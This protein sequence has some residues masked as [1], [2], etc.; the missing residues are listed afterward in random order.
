MAYIDEMQ[1][2]EAITL[3]L[4]ATLREIHLAE[5]TGQLRAITLADYKT[6]RT[7]NVQTCILACGGLE[8][9]R[10]MLLLA[11][12][13]PSVSQ[14]W[15]STL[16]RFYMGH[17]S[18]KIA[19]LVLRDPRTIAELDF[20]V[21]GDHFARRRFTLQ[22]DTLR[23]EQLLN[24]AFWADNPPF[25]DAKHRNGL[26]SAVWLLL[27]IPFIGRRLLSEGVRVSHV[28]PSPFQ[29]AGHLSNLVKSP[30]SV[31]WSAMQLLRDRYLCSPRKPGFI[32]RNN[33]GRYALHYHAEQLPT[34]S[35]FVSL[36]TDKDSLGVQRLVVDFNYC[37]LDATSVVR[38]HDILDRSLREANVG[39]L[40]YRTSR[41][42]LV[43][44]V[45]AQ[46]S[47]GFHQLGTTRMSKDANS[48]VVDE[49]CKVHGL[50]NLFLLSSSV[51]PSSGQANPTF[52]IVAFAFRLASYLTAQ[53]DRTQSSVQHFDRQ[54]GSV[55]CE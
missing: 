23:N 54:I 6:S 7:I 5:G 10:I 51:F 55:R 19:D 4:G 17:I 18:G 29:I 44:S 47:D 46:A 2:S 35:S 45:M 40:E 16:G 3:L 31:I 15:A 25:H 1:N 41:D 38:A 32:I 49:N 21:D 43:S 13:Y 26:L 11:Q 50:D 34:E 39:Y 30:F 27:A 22:K 53:F 36:A 28:G 24:I 48:G 14:R 12:S 9:T 52:Q 37:E 20:F 33:A 8:T 42:A